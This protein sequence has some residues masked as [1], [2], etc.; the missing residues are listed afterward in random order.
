MEEACGASTSQSVL[1]TSSKLVFT[2]FESLREMK[3]SFLLGV[4]QTL[5]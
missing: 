4:A 1:S 5:S 2:V 3:A